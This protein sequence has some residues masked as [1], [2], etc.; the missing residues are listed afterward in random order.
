MRSRNK[1]EMPGEKQ[2]EQRIDSK[3]ASRGEL[4][5]VRVELFIYM[6]PLM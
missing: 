3:E 2:V 4:P 5:K 1:L 6:L